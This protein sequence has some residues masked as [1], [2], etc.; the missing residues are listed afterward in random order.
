MT[1]GSHA[2]SPLIPQVFGDGQ[3]LLVNGFSLT[4][5]AE[6]LVPD[7]LYAMEHTWYDEY[8]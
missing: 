7:Q 8:S 1:P 2:H 6:P 3:W 5:F 4:F